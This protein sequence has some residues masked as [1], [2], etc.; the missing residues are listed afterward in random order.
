MENVIQF[1]NKQLK[2]LRDLKN[3]HVGSEQTSTEEKLRF[4]DIYACIPVKFLEPSRHQEYYLITLRK[5]KS[6][7]YETTEYIKV[8]LKNPLDR[9]KWIYPEKGNGMSGFEFSNVKHF[10]QKYLFLHSAYAENYLYLILNDKEHFHEKYF[11]HL[12]EL[13]LTL[14]IN[15]RD[16]YKYSLNVDRANEFG[17]MLSRGYTD[18]LDVIE[19]DKQQ[20]YFPYIKGL[21]A[22]VY[23]NSTKRLISLEAIPLR[24]GLSE[25]SEDALFDFNN[26]LF[27]ENKKYSE[28]YL[29][30]N[31]SY[32]KK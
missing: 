23:D 30:E 13:P 3:K 25:D 4:S 17:L 15:S 10:A 12:S 22:V 2:N 5:N 27:V 26:V 19:F 7:V 24:E 14:Q 31:L 1:P 32:S 11:R 21:T 20:T 8:D 18:E 9:D 6:F 28:A 29:N 16:N